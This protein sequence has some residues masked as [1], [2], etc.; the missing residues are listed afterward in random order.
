MIEV[1]RITA[2]LDLGGYSEVY[3]DQSVH[4]WVNPARDVIDARLNLMREYAKLVANERKENQSVFF[5]LFKDKFLSATEKRRS[6]L[7]AQLWSAGAE[8]DTRWSVEE[9]TKLN[10]A[11]PALYAWMVRES[12]RMVD[13][14]RAAKKK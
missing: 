13:E 2:P 10:D 11:D 14:F 3:K 12:W 9:I 8:E 5:A 6:G 4:V 7:M 1:K